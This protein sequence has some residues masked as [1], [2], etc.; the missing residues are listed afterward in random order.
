MTAG[1]ASFHSPRGDVTDSGSKISVT[2]ITRTDDALVRS[3]SAAEFAASSRDRADQ[4]LPRPQP[5]AAQAME[6]A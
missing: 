2:M 4:H 1:R 3:Q 5:V 6:V